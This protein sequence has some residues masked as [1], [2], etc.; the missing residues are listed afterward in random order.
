[1]DNDNFVGLARTQKACMTIKS[2]GQGPG[3]GSSSDMGTKG[4]YILAHI[5]ARSQYDNRIG[6]N[7]AEAFPAL[8]PLK[9]SLR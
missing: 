7:A 4:L 8:K 1:M 9:S 2:K 6:S 5:C 3:I